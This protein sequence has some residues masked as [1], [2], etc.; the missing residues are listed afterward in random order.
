MKILGAPNRHLVGLERI[1]VSCCDGDAS[2]PAVVPGVANAATQNTLEVGGVVWLEHA[3]L[4][5][6]VKVPQARNPKTQCTRTHQVRQQAYFNGAQSTFCVVGGHEGMGAVLLQL[7]GVE[8]N[9]PIVE[10]NSNVKEVSVDPGKIK[11]EKS[12]QT[13][14]VKHDVVAKEVGMDGAARKFSVAR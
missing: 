9:A 6:Q 10:A 12:S 5:W 11:V 8:V 2:T 14:L 3:G 13:I 7:A 4:A 1:E